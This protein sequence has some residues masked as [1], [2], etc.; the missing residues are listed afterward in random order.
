MR[1]SEALR[2]DLGLNTTS[3]ATDFTHAA[4]VRAKAR[5][6]GLEV[7]PCGSGGWIVAGA[8]GSF[9]V[10]SLVNISLADLDRLGRRR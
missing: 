1:K 6:L 5:S 7:R 8:S 2:A 4:L 9:R 3:C 10:N